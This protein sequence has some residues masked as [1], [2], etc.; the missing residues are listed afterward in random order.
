M[1]IGIDGRGYGSTYG[2]MGKYTKALVAHISEHT[3]AHE[4][5]LFVHDQELNPSILS[6]PRIQ[7]IT[8]PAGL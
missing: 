7:V 4:Y 3:D 5:V 2:Y 6:C 8:I 1:R